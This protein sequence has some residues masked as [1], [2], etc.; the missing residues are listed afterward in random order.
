[1]F[2]HKCSVS[3]SFVGAYILYSMFNI[4]IIAFL[5]VF[6][7]PYFFQRIYFIFDD[8][9]QIGTAEIKQ[10][11]LNLMKCLETGK[12]RAAYRIFSL[13]IRCTMDMT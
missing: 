9:E 4:F 11:H 1:M 8:P 3:F 12:Q 7:S 10:C 5:F 13:H 6:R 2:E